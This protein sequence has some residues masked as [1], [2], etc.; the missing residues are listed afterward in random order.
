M[1]KRSWGVMEEDHTLS[2]G[3]M[4]L[5][6]GVLSTQRPVSSG[7]LR[8]Q[9][10]GYNKRPSISRTTKWQKWWLLF[11]NIGDMITLQSCLP[12][13]GTTN[14]Y[15]PTWTSSERESCDVATVWMSLTD[16]K[17]DCVPPYSWRGYSFMMPEHGIQ[18]AEVSLTS[19][20]PTIQP[21]HHFGSEPAA[22]P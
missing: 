14:N 13:A 1:L 10:P 15:H 3:Y 17:N 21:H 8:Q 6:L 4:H 11:S 12:C 2:S 9:T 20:H 18:L 22:K 19:V 5:D 16:F 7:W